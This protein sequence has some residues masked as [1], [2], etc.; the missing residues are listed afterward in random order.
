M[1]WKLGEIYALTGT[2]RRPANWLY[3]A[4]DISLEHRQGWCLGPGACVQGWGRGGAGRL[5]LFVIYIQDSNSLGE[6]NP[7][8]LSEAVLDLIPGSEA[9]Q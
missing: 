4:Y 8:K 2:I 5:I 6:N 9:A 7:N 3:L 1:G